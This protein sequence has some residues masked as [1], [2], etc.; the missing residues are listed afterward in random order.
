MSRV[1]LVSPNSPFLVDA[2]TFPP[3]GLLY[4]GAALEAH[5]HDVSV[6]DLAFP[7]STLANHSPDLIGI[8]CLTP[9]FPQMP[10]LIASLRTLYP[11]V[12]IA[13]GGPHFSTVPADGGRVGADVT[14]V[15]DGEEQM[16]EIVS[17]KWQKGSVMQSPGGIV[18]VNRHPIPARHLL[19][20][21]AYRYQIAGLKATTAITQRGCLVAGTKVMLSSGHQRPIELVRKGDTVASFNP[22]TGKCEAAPVQT[23]WQREADDVWELTWA[24][25]QKL[26][27]TAEHPVWTKRGWVEVGHLEEERDCALVFNVSTGFLCSDESHEDSEVLPAEMSVG[28]AENP[29]KYLMDGSWAR[30]TTPARISND[31]NGEIKI[32][33]TPSSPH[34]ACP[35]SAI[36]DQ[37]GQTQSDEAPGSRSQ[38]VSYT[39]IPL[40]QKYVR[41]SGRQM[42]IGA[43]AL[44][45]GTPYRAGAEQFGA[46]APRTIVGNVSNL[47]LRWHRRILDRALSIWKK[48]QSR[49]CG[50]G[51]EEGNTSAWGVL[52]LTESGLYRTTGL[53]WSRLDSPCGMVPPAQDQE[54]APTAQK[55]DLVWKKLTGKR[56]VG[57]RTV[58]N[59]TVHPV[60]T[61]FADGV[62]VHNC[63][64]EC[65]FCCHWEGYRRVRLRHTDNI[66]VEVR[67]L[68]AQGFGAVMFYDDEFNLNNKRTLE[69]CDALKGEGIR[70]RAFVKA[71]CFNEEQA[72]AF[73]ESGCWELCTGVESGSDAVLRTIQ[74]K[75]SVAHNTDA[76]RLCKEYGI[77]FKAFVMVGHPGETLETAYAT[78]DWLLQN[79]PD[80]FN[81]SLYTPYLGTPVA[82]RPQDFD[83]AFD[84]LDY[85]QAEYFYRGKPGEYQAHARTTALSGEE[86]ARLRDEIETEVREKLGLPKQADP[87][88]WNTARTH[89][90]CAETEIG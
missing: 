37:K 55:T 81:L 58:Y 27:I 4:L 88:T 45:M 60:H 9:H 29:S 20:V 69:V 52:A 21:D 39:E 59:I 67:G 2:Q 84:K 70:W 68:K 83:L 65:T 85:S 89:D 79:A 57:K 46:L 38:G 42:E 44:S 31:C 86:L 80:E 26:Q 18:D 10:G 5:G 23:I 49:L 56:F 14:V 43:Y 15:G 73:S 74:K 36:S 40:G 8:M 66:I 25:G 61:Y 33:G 53:S 41:I 7:S 19:P 75:A 54:Q 13:V 72:R 87:R 34:K 51:P 71:N 24:D 28:L 32:L 50:C 3:L 35:A 6:V 17:G 90:A 62:V 22:D 11:S 30:Q 78:R 77:R 82:D 76:R 63:P 64:Y 16:V 48:T 47:S 12:P 1:L